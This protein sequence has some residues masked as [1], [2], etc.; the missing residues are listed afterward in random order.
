MIDLWPHKKITYQPSDNFTCCIR[1]YQFKPLF[2]HAI[3]KILKQNSI[4]P[5]VRYRKESYYI[6]IKDRYGGVINKTSVLSS[7]DDLITMSNTNSNDMLSKLNDMGMFPIRK[8][9]ESGDYIDRLLI[10]ET[11]VEFNNLMV[12]QEFEFC[13]EWGISYTNTI[14]KCVNKFRF[15][16]QKNKANTTI[17]GDMDLPS[18]ISHKTRM[19]LIVATQVVEHVSDLENTLVNMIKLLSN[20][21]YLIITVPHISIFHPVDGICAD[22]RR[23]THC[24]CTRISQNY[25]LNL[26]SVVNKGNSILSALILLGANTNDDVYKR[27]MNYTDGGFLQVGCLFQV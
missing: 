16:W 18:K 9:W 19:N 10:E 26:I 1:H 11:L 27:F 22:H 20:K 8:P 25:N 21:G 17:I 3:T 4:D 5:T 7:L 23:L 14:F 12:N 13:A 15:S 6:D 2:Q 24:S